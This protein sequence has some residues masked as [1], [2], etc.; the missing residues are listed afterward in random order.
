MDYF[1]SLISLDFVL[2]ARLNKLDLMFLMIV[3]LV[4]L[5]F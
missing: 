5:A 4:V 3:E 1:L 2:V